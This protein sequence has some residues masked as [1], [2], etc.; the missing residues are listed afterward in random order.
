MADL[1]EYYQITPSAGVAGAAP[2]QA[3]QQAAPR[4]QA[5]SNFGGSLSA[6]AHATSAVV[7]AIGLLGAVFVYLHWRE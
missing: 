2:G 5:M 6:N 7:L 3:P 1:S 4:G